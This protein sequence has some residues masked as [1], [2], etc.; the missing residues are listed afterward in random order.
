MLEKKESGALCVASRSSAEEHPPGAWLGGAG[1]G[2]SEGED[3]L[4]PCKGRRPLPESVLPPEVVYFDESGDKC[5]ISS[6]SNKSEE[7][8]EEPSNLIIQVTL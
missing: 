4:V 3:G 8:V 1:S 2:D 5:C 7:F 6:A